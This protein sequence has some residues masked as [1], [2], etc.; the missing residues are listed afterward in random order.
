[1]L[2]NTLFNLVQEIEFMIGSNLAQGGARS[3]L[4]NFWFGC[5]TKSE[6]SLQ[7]TRNEPVYFVE[8]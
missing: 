3:V 7:V 5:N 4:I 1:M 2:I 6:T 8:Q